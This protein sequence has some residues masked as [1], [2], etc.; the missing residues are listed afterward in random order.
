MAIVS[1]MFFATIADDS[2]SRIFFTK[3]VLSKS[4]VLYKKGALYCTTGVLIP[5]IKAK[6]PMEASIPNI[7]P[8]ELST[9]EERERQEDGK[10]RRITISGSRNGKV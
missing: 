3:N 8:K 9:E 5:L 10:N 7:K 2:A 4:Y 1:I 6:K